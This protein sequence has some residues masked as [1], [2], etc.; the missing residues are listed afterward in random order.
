[1]IM[2]I[3]SFSNI[4]QYQNAVNSIP[5]LSQEDET[6]LVHKYRTSECLKSAHKLVES[7]LRIVPGIARSFKKSGTPLEDLIQEGNIALMKAVRDFNPDFGVRLSS[8]A[9]KWVRYAIMEHVLQNW[10]PVK[11]ITTKSHRK[12]FYHLWKFKQS[13][14]SKTGR[15][16]LTLDDIDSFCASHDV[17]REEV[18]DTSIRLDVK[19]VPFESDIDNEEF[20]AGE[21]IEDY[22]TNPENVLENLELA[23]MVYNGI[24]DAIDSELNDREKEIINSRWIVVDDSGI[25]VTLDTLSKKLGIS[26]ER[27]RQIALGKI[28]G[29][30]NAK[31]H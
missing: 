14:Y 6:M 17:T 26:K 13:V 23:D 1:M 16:S 3:R 31:T 9:M 11:T 4:E 21:L 19:G 10:A 27:V 25:G 24:P 29:K 20:G 8:Y 30:L 28:K 5:M 22:S 18:L 2:Q 15:T 12:I 7:Y